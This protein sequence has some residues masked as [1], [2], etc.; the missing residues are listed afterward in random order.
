MWG[1]YVVS[2]CTVNLNKKDLYDWLSFYCLLKSSRWNI[3]IKEGALS[4]NSGFISSIADAAIKNQKLSV[5]SLLWAKNS[6]QDEFLRVGPKHEEQALA[7]E[8]LSWARGIWRWSVQLQ[9]LFTNIFYWCVLFHP[10]ITCPGVISLTAEALRKIMVALLGVCS[11]VPSS[12]HPM[13]SQGWFQCR[14]ELLI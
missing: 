8:E 11:A 7:F 12:E 6:G 13:G 1:M 4:Q 3:C 14:Q 10:T 9:S 2:W 5:N